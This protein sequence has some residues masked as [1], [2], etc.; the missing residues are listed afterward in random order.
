MIYCRAAPSVILHDKLLFWKKTERL[1]VVQFL[2]SV[3]EGVIAPST[4]WLKIFLTVII[5]VKM[6]KSKVLISSE[7][8]GAAQPPDFFL[9]LI[10]AWIVGVLGNY[11]Y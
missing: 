7:A 4:P 9:I 11:S 2:Y 10:W 1:A 3:V 6:Q 5:G 8:T